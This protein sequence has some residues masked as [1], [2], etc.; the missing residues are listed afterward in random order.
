MKSQ[1]KEEAMGLALLIIASSFF[2]LTHILLSHGRIREGLVSALGLLGFRAVYSFISIVPLGAA[3]WMMI[4]LEGPEK[5]AEFWSLS[6]YGYPVVYLLMLAAFILVVQSFFNPSPTGMMQ[7]R[8]EVTGILRVTRHPMNMGVALFGLAHLM[9]N[10]V[11]ADLFF[12]GSLFL[13]GLI[14]AYHQD[15]R[16]SREKG[17]EYIEFKNNSSILPFAGIIIGKNR[18]ARD[19]IN[20]TGL[21]IALVAFA[22]FF[23]F[24]KSL[25]GSAPF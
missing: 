20:K 5:G 16:K 15:R 14:G 25:F 21:I 9:A 13:T 12:F 4:V 2:F 11:P 17:Q 3:V 22:L 10:G 23:V 19:E 7:E 6:W 8:A 18:L 24:H 1:S